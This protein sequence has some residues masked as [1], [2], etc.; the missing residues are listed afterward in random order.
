VSESGKLRSPDGHLLWEHPVA[1]TSQS[2][3]SIPELE[4]PVVADLD[5]DGKPEVIVPYHNARFEKHGWV[6]I[7]VLD[8]ATGQSRWRQRLSRGYRGAAENIPIAHFVVGPDLDG[9]GCREIF[10]AA[11]IDEASSDQPQRLTRWLVVAATSGADGRLLWRKLLPVDR[12]CYRLGPLRW[13]SAG[14]DG[15]PQLA[16]SIIGTQVN[17]L[18]KETKGTVA[19]T[20]LFASAD[21]NLEHRWRGVSR[22]DTAD[23]DGDGISDLYCLRLETEKSGE[24]YG[25]RGGLPETRRL[26]IWQPAVT[27]WPHEDGQRAPCACFGSGPWRGCGKNSMTRSDAFPTTFKGT[28]RHPRPTSEP[29][30]L[31]AKF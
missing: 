4:W 16:V 2:S 17:W 5:G 21:G 13:A 31:Y 29:T 18:R 7:E 6:G 10:T 22:V 9:D 30:T 25:L 14:A 27:S 20:V 8:G 3:S 28:G 23:F 26:G 19:Q 24:L 12:D 15:R 11:L 1:P